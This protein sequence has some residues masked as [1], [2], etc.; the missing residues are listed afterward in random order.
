MVGHIWSCYCSA[1]NFHSEFISWN[2]SQ[3]SQVRETAAAAEASAPQPEQLIILSHFG[4]RR[5]WMVWRMR[6]VWFKLLRLVFVVGWESLLVA[7]HIAWHDLCRWHCIDCIDCAICSNNNMYLWMLCMKIISWFDRDSPF[8][9]RSHVVALMQFNRCS[10]HQK[11][12]MR[13]EYAIFIGLTAQKIFQNELWLR[14]WL[15]VVAL[16]YV[17]INSTLLLARERQRVQQNSSIY[18]MKTISKDIDAFFLLFCSFERQ[19]PISLAIS[20]DFDL[21][22]LHGFN[23]FAACASHLPFSVSICNRPLYVESYNK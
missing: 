10:R 2:W 7:C 22:F 17:Q 11:I 23:L 12:S 5:K 8:S 13:N 15:V 9:F 3:Q 19:N 18:S 16:A 1:Y 21:I 4:W 14:T 20:C 6:C